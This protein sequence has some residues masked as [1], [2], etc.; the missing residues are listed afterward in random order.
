MYML[1]NNFLKNSYTKFIKLPLS[2]KLTIYFSLLLLLKIIV[3]DDVFMFR[4]IE[5]MTVK[6]KAEFDSLKGNVEKITNYLE[7]LQG[8]DNSLMDCQITTGEDEG[9]VY[10]KNIL[11]T[12]TKPPSSQKYYGWLIGFVSVVGGAILI[13]GVGYMVNKYLKKASGEEE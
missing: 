1:R 11:A 13:G 8:K 7:T 6:E 10:Q 12:D 9:D 2:F 3:V 4:R 5:A